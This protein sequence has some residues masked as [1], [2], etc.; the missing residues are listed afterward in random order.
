MVVLGIDPGVATV[1]F[2]AINIQGAST[3][4]IRYGIIS[5][6]AKMQLSQRLYQIKSDMTE[7]IGIINPDAIAVEE[8][9]FTKN[10]KTGIAVAHGR[11]SIL[12][13]GQ[14][15]AVPMFEYTP[16]QVKKAI[17]GH[18]KATKKQVMDMVQ[19]L[20]KLSEVPKPDDAADALAIALCH[21]RA[22]KSVLNINGGKECST[23]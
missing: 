1:G 9:F 8:L 12:L 18:G 19:R 2:G 10:L 23:I 17:A 5:T 13:A 3:T 15:C 4:L 16:L 11:A 21:A 20:L 7:L 6:P 22:A 14:E